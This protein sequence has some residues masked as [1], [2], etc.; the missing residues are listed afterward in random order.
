MINGVLVER[1]VGEVLPTLQTNADGLKE[2]M[3]SLVKQY[4]SKQE[5]MEKWKVSHSNYAARMQ[6]VGIANCRAEKEQCPSGSTVRLLHRYYL[7]SDQSPL[8]RSVREFDRCYDIQILAE[9]YA[10]LPTPAMSSEGRCT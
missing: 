1:T 6:I 9:R 2:V 10:K 4:K 7:P 3:E 8:P 5:E